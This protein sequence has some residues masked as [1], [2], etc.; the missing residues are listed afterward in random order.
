MA[1]SYVFQA[2]EQI[3]YENSQGKIVAQSNIM[4]CLVSYCLLLKENW[5]ISEYMCGMVHKSCTIHLLKKEYEGKPGK[6][7]Y[8]KSISII[9]CQETLYKNN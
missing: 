5:Y 7:A 6:M 3:Y 9:L 2:S 1:S 8:V 4:K